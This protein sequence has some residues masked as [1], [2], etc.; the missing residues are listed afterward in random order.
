MA[1][2]QKICP[3]CKKEFMC[4][5]ENIAV[6]GCSQVVLSNETKSYLTKTFFSCL[7]T[8][9]LAEL[10][11]LIGLEKEYPFPGRGGDLI[12]GIHYY[13]EGEYRVFTELYLLSRG[14]C[15]RSGCRHCPYGFNKRWAE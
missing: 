5:S 10:N 15:C 11:D 13:K 1:D 3:R 14:F 9:C 12:E 2:K 7:C 4:N 8:T 6:C